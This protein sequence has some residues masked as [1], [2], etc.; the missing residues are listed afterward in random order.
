MEDLIIKYF[1]GTL[2]QEEKTNL[3]ERIETDEGVRSAFISYKNLY[4][5]TR[6]LPQKNDRKFAQAHLRSF[7]SS[8]KN[9]E[10]RRKYHIGIRLI[11][12]ISAAAAIII[13]VLIFGI[14]GEKWENSDDFASGNTTAPSYSN[15]LEV[16]ATLLNEEF[17]TSA[18]EI[19]K[20][21]LKDGSSIWLNANTIVKVSN[22]FNVE[23]RSVELISGEAYFDVAHNETLPFTVSSKGYSIKV[24]GTKFNVV[25]YEN[26][27]FKT[28]LLEGSIELSKCTEKEEILKIVPNET[29]EE[30]KGE[31]ISKS[32]IDREEL[33]W[34]KGVLSF[35][36]SPLEVVAQRFETCYGISIEIKDEELTKYPVSGKIRIEGGIETAF[37]ALQKALDFKYI[38]DKS[39]NRYIITI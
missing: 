33:M 9:I 24:L 13:G 15:A 26:I 17:S 1:E 19:K 8:L 11:S 21:T 12:S 3:F 30:I 32:N 34:R 2:S 7:K 38:Y 6:S 35:R 29:V 16:Q 22:L 28:S 39:N 18:G 14:F 23:N 5:L 37:S 25:A 27:P 20:V 36:N 10:P 4:A 31:L